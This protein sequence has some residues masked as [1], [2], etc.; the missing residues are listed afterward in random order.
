[1][2]NCNKL[3]YTTF[4]VIYEIFFLAMKEATEAGVAL[5]TSKQP[6]N[7]IY[8]KHFF[9]FKILNML[10][11]LLLLCTMM[12]SIYNDN[13]QYI[14]IAICLY[15]SNVFFWMYQLQESGVCSVFLFFFVHL[16]RLKR[17]YL[18]FLNI[19]THWLLK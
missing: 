12:Y 18:F 7:V 17:C 11:L 3:W 9:H 14:Y 2:C 15:S 5:N 10:I 13:I 1:M 6:N 16:Q 4:D 8:E 19:E